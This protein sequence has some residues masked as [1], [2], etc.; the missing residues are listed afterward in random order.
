MIEGRGFDSRATKLACQLAVAVGLLLAWQLASG[1]LVS[2]LF[3][4]SPSDVAVRLWEFAISGRLAFHA[5]LT[6]VHV[7]GGFAL[8]SVT[9]LAAG[10]LLSRTRRLADVLDP[11]I[12]AFYSLP[13]VALAPLFVVWFGI[14]VSMKILFVGAIVFL[15]VFLNTYTGARS[16]LPGQVAVLRLM[17]ASELQITRML[18]LP[19]AVAW[20]FAGLRLSV[21]YALTGAIIGEMVAS[22]RG[23]GY[24]IAFSS[25][26]LD[27]AGTFAALVAVVAMALVLNGLV[28]LAE[29]YAMPWRRA[30]SARELSI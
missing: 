1:R 17:R 13:K 21:P 27:T 8:G 30:D 26:Q 22:N 3:I 4:S 11:F 2:P 18:I 28:H 20:V 24:L 6:A 23:L 12:M 15:L 14:D 25:A 19:S 10:L 29:R 9:G 7:I 16:V 5:S